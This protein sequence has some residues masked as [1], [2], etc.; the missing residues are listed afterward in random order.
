MMPYAAVPPQWWLLRHAAPMV[1]EGICYGQLDVSADIEQTHH[2]ALGFSR[3]IQDRHAANG[4][5]SVRLLASPL[6]R[7]LQLARA[8]QQH[9]QQGGLSCTLETDRRLMEM[10][11]GAWEGQ[12]WD[13]V[14]RQEWDHWMAD[15]SGYEV[16]QHGESL[17]QMM[18]R[19]QRMQQ[20]QL[21]PQTHEWVVWVT[22]AGVIKALGLLAQGLTARDLASPRQWPQESCPYGHWL[23]AP[24]AH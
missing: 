7:C 1:Q 5:T 11:F 9:V 2:A 4:G 19:V 12:P 22:H 13:G 10:N 3:F 15:F 14:S 23:A 8:V 21:P 6:Q 18:A 24:A 17:A 20:E 16:G